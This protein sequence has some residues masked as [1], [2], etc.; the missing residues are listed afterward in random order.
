MAQLE[1]DNLLVHYN[2]N[3][4]YYF[5]MTE[6][7]SGDTEVGKGKISFS[8]ASG[9]Q[10]G[11]FSALDVT[12]LGLFAQDSINFAGRFTL[13]LGIRFDHSTTNLKEVS[14]S[15][16]GNP[17]SIQLGDQFIQPAS[18]LNP[19]ATFAGFPSWRNMIAWDTFSPRLG[20]SFDAFGNGRTIIKASYARY[21][22]L[23]RIQNLIPLSTLYFNRSHDFVWYDINMDGQ[24]DGEDTYSPFPYD[25]RFYDD[26]Y[27]QMVLDQDLKS[28]YVDEYTL[29]IWSEIFRGLSLRVN[30][31]L[32]HKKNI[33]ENV[34]YSPDLDVSWYT[35]ERA[36]EGWWIPFNT[37]VPGTEAYDPTSLTVY[38]PSQDAPLPFYRLQNVP[39][40][41]RQYQALEFILH[42]RM[43]NNWQL[44]ASVV[45]SKTTGNI[46]VGAGFPNAFSLA[47]DSANYFVNL[48]NTSSL[49]FD[50]P[51]T[52]KVMG[53]YR[54][55]YDFYLSAY[56]MHL[57]GSPWARSV[58]I[59]PPAEWTEQ[60]NTLD[61]PSSVLL[62]MPG[63]RRHD[64][65]N[66]LNLRVEKEFRL[67]RFGWFGI[68]LDIMNLLGSTY[69]L[70]DLN[71]GGYWMPEGENTAVGT[72]VIS[73]N[74]DTGVNI[75][76][77]REYR[78]T[79]RLRF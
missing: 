75:L 18:D 14:K 63:T 3:S 5:G 39:E 55:P 65:Y 1:T 29:G 56:Y 34:L 2:N 40:L 36:P 57:S 38:F 78:L 23:L 76:G 48:P 33:M 60:E 9:E 42:K 79:F 54:F 7:P 8:L 62:E 22:E 69:F 72:R 4:P 21:H 19:Y 67:K 47:A 30:Y 24:V 71:D 16:S 32:K 70:T 43:S 64:A 35:K 17:L 51:L 61:F 58:T 68:S 52:I 46:G 66:N 11:F 27:Y 10:G 77:T 50:I 25:F 73:P 59:I 45:F 53:T 26:Q 49:D 6:A 44:H 28:P 12:R 15:D 13:N 31:I 41:K 20:L 74:Y 37:T